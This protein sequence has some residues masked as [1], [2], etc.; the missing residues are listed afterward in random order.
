MR[1]ESSDIADLDLERSLIA[2]LLA[3]NGGFDRVGQLE[4]DDFFDPTHASVLT[5]ALDL[6]AE[7]RPVN[8]VTLRSRFAAVPFRDG[9]MVID[10]LKRLEFAGKV[11]EVSDMAA[12]VCELSRRR[13]IKALGEQIA[14][15]V[16]DHSVGPPVLL[17]DAARSVDDL[18]AKCRPSGKT[19][20]TMHDAVEEL[21]AAKDDSGRCIPTGL[22][23]L[24]HAM[25]GG[26]RRGEFDVLGGRTSMGKSTVGTAIGRRAARAGHGVMFFSIE[27]PAIDLL[28]R[29]ATD[30]CWSRE[31]VVDYQLARAGKLSDRERIAYERGARSLAD[32]PLLIEERSGLTA[33]EIASGTR[34]AAELFDRQGKKLGLVIVDHLGKVRPSAHYRGQKVHELGEISEA[35]THLAKS[36]NVAVLGLHQLN[37]AVESRDNKRPQLSDLR[38][39]GNLEQDADT[40][41]LAY[42]PGY[43]LERARDDDPNEER[44]RIENLNAK[45]NDLELQ[46]AKQRN[47][48]ICT[49]ELFCDMGAN[50]VRD[51]WRTVT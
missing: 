18:L 48:P 43:Y 27:M 7:R 36:E 26:M 33:S 41:L 8:I 23:D 44:S 6:H 10:Y 40:V 28:C 35:M 9:E 47:G 24:D 22:S 2:S 17:T 46:I 30:A 15:S 12:S 20:W 3:D 38:E 29:M 11:P 19:L 42:R 39:S 4:P 34:R 14:S 5:A 25:G 50:A 16:H 51:K 1:S 31:L 21:L 45:R 32:L 49:V 13:A 37:R